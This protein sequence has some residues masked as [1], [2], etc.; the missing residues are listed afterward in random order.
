MGKQPLDSRLRGN[1]GREGEND[2][3]ERAGMTVGDKYIYR[4]PFLSR[5]I[6]PGRYKNPVY[7]VYPCK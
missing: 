1:D 5:R 6:W 3:N 2:G 4:I 7:P